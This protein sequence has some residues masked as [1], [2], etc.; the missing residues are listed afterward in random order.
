MAGMPRVVMDRAECVTCGQN[1]EAAE[2]FVVFDCP[3][4]GEEIARCKRCKKL[5]NAFECSCGDFRG[6]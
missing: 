3:A 2:S 1:L 5:K 6:P 4:C